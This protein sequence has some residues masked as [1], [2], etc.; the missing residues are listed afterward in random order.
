MEEGKEKKKGRRT[1]PIEIESDSKCGE[2]RVESVTRARKTESNIRKRWTERVE[3]AISAVKLV[4]SN[5]RIKPR[6]RL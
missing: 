2:T 4:E 3:R 6:K 5:A 1:R